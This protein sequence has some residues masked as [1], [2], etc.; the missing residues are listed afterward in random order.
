[1]LSVVVLSILMHILLML[2]ALSV[3]MA[4]VVLSILV[5]IL[6]MLNAYMLSVVMLSVVL[7]ECRGALCFLV[8]AKAFFSPKRYYHLTSFNFKFPL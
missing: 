4:N 8:E 5:H 2:N 6:L 3:V 1:M 7:G